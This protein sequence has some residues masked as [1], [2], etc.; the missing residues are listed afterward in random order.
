M[1]DWHSFGQ[2]EIDPKS[3]DNCEP[4]PQPDGSYRFYE[5][6]ANGWE[7]SY[8]W[9][10]S[11]QF[12]DFGNDPDGYYLLRV[13]ANPS[14]TSSR[15]PTTTTSPTPTCRSAATTSA[16]SSAATDSRPGIPPRSSR[17]P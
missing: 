4:T 1:Y 16:S 5:G 11:G 3:I 7:D 9:Q 2:S 17:T 10:T 15:R 12:I 8:K 14:T 13:V 6:I